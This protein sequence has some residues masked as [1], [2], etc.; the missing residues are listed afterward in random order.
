LSIFQAIILGIV[1]G[2]CEFVPIS[3]SGHLIIVPW[4]LQW[5]YLLAHP[6]LNKTFD[7]ALHLGTFFA[8]LV[9]YW[10]AIGVIL[11]DFFGSLRRRCIATPG[12]HLAWMLLISTIPAGVLGVAFE[13]VVEDQLGK[14]WLIGVL[15]IAFGAVI[16]LI[17]TRAL[18]LREVEDVGW[19]AAVG[20]GFAQALALAPGVSR[21]G[22]TMMAGR[23]DEL[24]RDA[25]VRYAFLLSVPV[26]GGAALYKGLELAKTGLPSGMAGP[27]LAGMLA[28][29][30]SGFAAIW[31]TV[32]Y[33]RRH[34][35]KLFAIYRFVAGG[36]ILLVILFGLRHAGG[37]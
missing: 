33:L 11:R 18:Q 14:P 34:S 24:S 37:V 8:V 36:I 19:R 3:S 23:V 2:I 26:V 6:D 21:S 1:Q 7:V 27:F 28:A 10:S 30:V 4:L 12:E 13:K 29:A 9:Y 15:M 5:N 32:A 25:A 35:F 31:F 20:I 17:D 16:W 22:V